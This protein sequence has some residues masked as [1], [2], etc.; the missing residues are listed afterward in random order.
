MDPNEDGF[1]ELALSANRNY[2]KN[3]TKNKQVIRE[4]HQK[5]KK[6]LHSSPQHLRQPRNQVRLPLIMNPSSHLR[7]P[8]IGSP[9]L[10][11]R[12]KPRHSRTLINCKTALKQSRSDE[13]V[14]LFQPDSPSVSTSSRDSRVLSAEVPRQRAG[15]PATLL[16]SFDSLKKPVSSATVLRDFTDILTFYERKELSENKEPVF[17]IGQKALGRKVNDF[18]DEQGFYNAVE[19]DH[20]AYRY[21]LLEQLGEGA[22]GAVHRVFD[23]KKRTQLAVK[24]LRDESKFIEIGK[25]EI[26]MLKHIARVDLQNNN[27]IVHIEDCFMFRAHLCITFELLSHSLYE[28]LKEQNFNGLRLPAVRTI[29][30]QIFQSLKF[31]FKQAIIHCDLKPENILL[32]PSSVLSVKIIDF[33]S[34]CFQQDRAAMY[35]QSRYYRAPEIVLCVNYGTSIDVWSAGCILYELASG[36]PLFPASSSHDLFQR[37]VK[38]LGM[39]PQEMI[40]K[41]PRAVVKKYFKDITASDTSL[42]VLLGGI[43]PS[44]ADLIEKCLRWN[45][46]ERISPIQALAHPFL[47]S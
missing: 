38:L 39:P 41:V 12:V 6:S 19:G 26:S 4:L 7:N 29:T 14:V 8:T 30:Q 22:F 18:N 43:E 36:Y 3:A 11:S 16:K 47:R 31:L 32:I 21:E 25:H 24:I 45:P 34:S 15:S 42:R 9:V 35:L 37:I 40:D 28:L 33:G 27:H 5:N 1:P 23:H 2:L 13:R 10:N 17:Y 46:K 20:I 44:L